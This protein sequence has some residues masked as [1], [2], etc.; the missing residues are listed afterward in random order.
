M[1]LRGA[2]AISSVS[3]RPRAQCTAAIAGEMRARV[4]QGESLALIFAPR[5]RDGSAGWKQWRAQNRAGG[6][7]APNRIT[8]CQQV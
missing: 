3:R 1:A 7:I 8:Q 4:K 6:A 2:S 5:P